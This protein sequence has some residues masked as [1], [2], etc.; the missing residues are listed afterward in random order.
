M[1]RTTG[2]VLA[3]RRSYDVGRKPGQRPESRRVFGGAWS[4]PVCVLTHEPCGD[5]DDP[6]ITFLSSAVRDAVS[7][8]LQ[9]A[10]VDRLRAKDPDLART[11]LY[12]PA[13]SGR[14]GP[15]RSPPG[16]YSK[17]SVFSPQ[18]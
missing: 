10:A 7:T 3:E 1:I 16:G 2:A 5:E 9:A 17:R 8:A 18:V 14:P 12:G 11:H 15:K 4:G 13:L 6:A